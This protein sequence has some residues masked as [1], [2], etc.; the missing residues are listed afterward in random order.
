M[1]WVVRAQVDGVRD[2]VAGA[3][4]ADHVA[5]AHVAHVVHVAH[6]HVVV[7][8]V[9]VVGVVVVAVADHSVHVVNIAVV[10]IAVVT[11]VAA[12]VVVVFG[13]RPAPQARRRPAYGRGAVVAK[14]GGPGG[15]SM[16]A[17]AH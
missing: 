13:A 1:H 6:V 7:V 3:H 4:V 12:V 5:V 16:P 14:A 11:V 17:P 9:G 8:V 2:H 10:V 15:R